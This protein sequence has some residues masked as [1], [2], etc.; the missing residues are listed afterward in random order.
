MAKEIV[1]LHLLSP[2]HILRDSIWHILLGYFSQELQHLLVRHPLTAM[3]GDEFFY[4][5]LHLAD[6][7]QVLL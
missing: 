7:L 6:Q 1:V 2:H 5:H 4:H 3:D